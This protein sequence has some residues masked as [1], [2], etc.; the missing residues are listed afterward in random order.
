MR[1]A[2][3][4]TEL[5][6]V[7]SDSGA[8]E[9]S[10]LSWAAALARDERQ[11]AVC[12]DATAS[13]PDGGQLARFQPDLVVLN[14]RP[15]FAE[16]LP[17]GLPV[18]HLFHNYPDAWGVP[19]GGDEALRRALARPRTTLCAVSGALARHVEETLATGPVRCLQLPVEECF[20]ATDWDGRGGPVLFPNRLLE[21]KGVRFFLEL[22]SELAG[23]GLSCV[24]F[25][26]LAPWR[27]PTPEQ[28]ALLSL[29]AGQEAAALLP[30]PASREQMAR[31][32][33]TAGVVLCPSV[34]PEGLGLVALE[35][36]AV[37]APLV[38]SGLGGLGEA[39]FSPNEVVRGFALEDWCAAVARAL[40]RPRSELPSRRVA[41]RHSERASLASLRAVLGGAREES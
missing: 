16:R 31:A 36:Q 24:L 1:V 37:G 9:R 29:V 5:A 23:K 41:E 27:E 26:H 32:Y 33:A 7:R 12:L 28:E 30:A 15:L 18:L 38:T 13:G 20:F 10:L 35:A 14:N 25:S 40:A 6:P 3:V 11:S 2:F 4:G 22:A 34:R 39:T 8:L 17:A 21:K 19:P